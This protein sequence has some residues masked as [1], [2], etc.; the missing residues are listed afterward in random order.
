[1]IPNKL[2]LLAVAAFLIIVPATGSAQSA[3][4]AAQMLQSNPGLLRELRSRIM[5]SGLTPDQVRARLRAEGYPE[6]LL[7]AYLPG[8]T[9]IPDSTI[10]SDD[11]FLALGE[12]GIADTTDLALLRCGINVDTLTVSDTLPSGLIDTTQNKRR[13]EEQRRLARQ[14]CIAQEDSLRRGL[15][16]RKIDADSGF[17]DRKSVV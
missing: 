17:V 16:T 6:T 10:S 9:G 7:D 15:L 4:Q 11:V 13:V 12:L 8:A 2:R 14:R 3:S 5:S 1:M